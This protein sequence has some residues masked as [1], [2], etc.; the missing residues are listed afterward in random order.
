[1]PKPV[2]LILGFGNN[3]GANVASRFAQAGFDVAV[4]CRKI[5]KECIL[6]E[7]LAIKKDLREAEGL[8][9][10]FEEVESAYGPPAVVVYNVA[11]GVFARPGEPLSLQYSDIVNDATT[12]GLNAFEAARLANEAFNKLPANQSRVFIATGNQLV[13]QNIPHLIGLSIGKRALANII[14]ACATA[15]GDS[16]KR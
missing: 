10:V 15:Y 5:E 1:M 7:Y 6:P 3:I 12:T 8:A 4:V 13:T 14:E 2:I 9:A 11:Q 16:G